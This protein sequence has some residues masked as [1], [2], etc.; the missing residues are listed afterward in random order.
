MSKAKRCDPGSCRFEDEKDQTGS[1]RFRLDRKQRRW[2]HSTG[3]AV[4]GPNELVLSTGSSPTTVDEQFFFAVRTVYYDAS[5]ARTISGFVERNKI[6]SDGEFGLP[7]LVGG[8]GKRRWSVYHR[9][10][11]ERWCHCTGSTPLVHDT[12]ARQ[13]SSGKRRI[14]ESHHHFISVAGFGGD[15]IRFRRRPWGSAMSSA[16]TAVRR[17]TMAGQSRLALLGM[18]DNSH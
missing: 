16:G 11:R 5:V 6:E 3:N 9:N 7:V 15:G 18:G 14:L 13:S 10:Y 17:L 8:L 2:R 4:G 12:A 1:D